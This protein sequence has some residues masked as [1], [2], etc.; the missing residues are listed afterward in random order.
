MQ[1]SHRKAAAFGWASLLTALS[2]LAA[3]GTASAATPIT[4]RHGH[5]HGHAYGRLLGIHN[6][7]RFTFHAHTGQH[8]KVK[9]TGQGPTRGTVTS[10]GGQQD[11][12][13]GGVVFDDTVTQTGRYRL[14]VTEDTMAEAWHGRVRVDVYR[15]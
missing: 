12:S 6:R 4:F 1:R 13:P 5:T 7:A 9:I 10:P 11:G 14:L 2:S 15:H 8:V 3:I